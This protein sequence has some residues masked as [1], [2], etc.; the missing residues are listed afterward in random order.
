VEGTYLKVQE[1]LTALQQQHQQ[2]QEENI[3]LYRKV[4]FMQSY[5]SSRGGNSNAGRVECYH[6]T[7]QTPLKAPRGMSSGGGGGYDEES[8]YSDDHGVSGYGHHP[9]S[10]GDQDLESKYAQL[11]ETQL[12]PFVEFSSF[13]KQRKLS[14][15]NV[16]DRIVLNTALAI[17]S[18]NFGRK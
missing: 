1:Q 18:N 2:L 16:A 6:H 15:L 4:K 17:I 8:R 5:Q 3:S 7:G 12:N 9:N 10:S 14:E 13:E 11:Y